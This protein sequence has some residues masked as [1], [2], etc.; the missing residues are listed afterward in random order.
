M[1]YCGSLVNTDGS[2]QFVPLHLSPPLTPLS[3]PHLY[4]K[5]YMIRLLLARLLF[6][7]GN[8]CECVFACLILFPAAAATKPATITDIH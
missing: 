8:S 3:L 7:L 4:S 2:S 1:G 6:D 5:R